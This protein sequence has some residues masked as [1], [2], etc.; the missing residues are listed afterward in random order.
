MAGGQCVDCGYVRCIAALEFHHRDPAT[1]EFG[2]G[3]FDGS[4]DK[5]IA[6]AAKCDLLCASCHRIRHALEDEAAERDR[7]LEA[8]R[9]QKRRAVQYMG[10]VCFECGRDGP[11]ALF[12]FHHLDA[13]EK[14]FGISR[15]GTVRPWDSVVAEL[16]KCV[17][18]CANC[19]R[20]A[21]AGVRTIRPTLL[22]LAED[23]L[24]YVA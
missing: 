5:L 18:L 20:E 24:P 3:S 13:R 14:D 19:H 4:L 22:G 2:L 1:K 16:D 17:M 8:R 7:T 11:F 9:E 15:S 21:H 10:S 6:E 12:E 23:A